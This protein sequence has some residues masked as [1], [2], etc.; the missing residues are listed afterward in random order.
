MAFHSDLVLR[1]FQMPEVPLISIV[2][3]DA[4]A[5]DGIRE[6]VESLGYKTT[7]FESAEHFLQSSMVAETACLITDLQMPGLSGLELQ[8]ALQSRGYRTPI[9]LITAFP[10]EKDR[11]RALDNGAIGFLSKPFDK[12]SLIKYLTAAISSAQV[13]GRFITLSSTTSMQDSGLLGHILPLFK[14]ASGIDVHVVAVGTGQALAM[15]TR[16][17]ADALLVHDWAGEDK[18]VADGFG[19]DRRDVMYND[20]V[21]VGPS[22]DPAR[23]R[24]LKNAQQAL[25]QIAE[26]RAPFASRGDDSGTHR[27]ELRLW[28]AAGIA[29][30]QDSGWHRGV[31]QG[32]GATLR[33]A[34]GM[35]AYTLTDRA[36][37]ANFKN[38][39]GLEILTEVDPD[40]FN[41]YGSILINPAKWPNVKFGDAK[42]WHEWLTTKSG[43][44]AIESYHINGEEM[45]FT[46]LAEFADEMIE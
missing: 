46:Q 23:I 26:A 44:D 5:R 24:G 12:K 20:F 40:L 3:D 31:A 8:E 39:Q 11:T 41:P 6:F 14:A 43:R 15:G 2:D 37:W 22:R 4:L 19:I 25:S 30:D 42:I 7:T 33:V 29:V 45:F 21:I 34:A 27:T 16:G 13:V 36:T 9:I 32:M 1:S 10:N 28:K 35:N 17:E 18:F 38:G